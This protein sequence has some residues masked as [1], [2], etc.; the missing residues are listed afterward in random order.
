[1]QYNLVNICR[2]DEPDIASFVLSDLLTFLQVF[3][4]N[5][6]LPVEG[7]DIKFGTWWRLG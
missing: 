7:H 5:Y 6:T 2:G 1:M 4:T 3:K